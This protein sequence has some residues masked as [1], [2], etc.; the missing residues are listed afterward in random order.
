MVGLD[1]LE[2]F[3]DFSPQ[4]KVLAITHLTLGTS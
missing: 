1:F 2:T 4:K 3:G